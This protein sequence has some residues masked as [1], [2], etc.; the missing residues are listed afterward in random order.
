MTSTDVRPPADAERTPPRTST[1]SALKPLVLRLHFYAG[2]LVAPFLLVAAATGLLYA[3]SFQ[4]ERIVHAHELTVPAGQQRVPLAQQIA[5]AQ[6][7]RPTGTITA[8]RIPAEADASTR[9]LMNVPGLPE[10]TQLAV[11]VDPYTAQVRG[12]LESY[13]GSGALPVRAWI[14]QLHR[15]LHLGEPG[16][17]Y[18]ELA[19]SWLWVVALGGLV[20]WV[21]RRR[22]KRRVRALLAPDR[23]LPASPR[24][25]S[26][27]GSIG[28]WAVLG[29]LFLS[30][31][32]L[33][34][35]KY[36]GENVGDVRV[37]LGW[38]TPKISAASG[39]HAAHAG[40]GG[41][42]H[43]GTVSADELV[44]AA[45]GKGLSGPLEIVWPAK[46]GA[47]FVVKEID[48]TVPQRLDQVAVDGTSG[49]VTAELRF[50]DFNLAA[51]LTQWGIDGHM[52]LLF[53]LAN[54]LVLMLL[55]A[56]VITLVILGYR[57]WWK[58]RP[59]RGFGRPYARG[60]WRGVRWAVL[61]PLALVV[62]G[63]GWFLPVMG[64]SLAAFLVVDVLL[65]LRARARPPV[66]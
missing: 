55:A 45:A 40:A 54:Q 24:R 30:A 48:K 26:W 5:A 20:L 47:P 66:G 6:A 2:V 11:F 59:T 43:G 35:S 10:S 15:H 34:W 65:G 18:S 58:R 37:A 17:L 22:S 39:D 36:A 21:T 25:L 32:G 51:K 38:T 28:L 64:F 29:L 62:A 42:R 3:A 8:V 1:W 23:S 41:H 52:G 16:R 19:A 60:G 53:G 33:T 14:S 46:E 57:M 63:I 49:Q 56:G 61:A 44:R 13:G 9:V 50:A 7:A 12:T 31:T 4:L 27:H